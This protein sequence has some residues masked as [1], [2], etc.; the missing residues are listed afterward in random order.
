MMSPL[1]SALL[2]LQYN[3]A[4]PVTETPL[5]A[6]KWVYRETAERGTGFGGHSATL[7]SDDGR[8]RLVVRCDFSYQ[9]DISIQFLRA[10]RSE[11]ITAVPVKLTR[12][13]SDET[14]ALVWEQAASGTFA[15]DGMTD[16]EATQAA[17]TLQD[18]NGELKVEARDTAGRRLK[19]T[20]T[21]LAGHDAIRRTTTACYDL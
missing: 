19:V 7:L 18:Y 16:V 2:I 3:T 6:G 8:Y 10:F 21:A 15:R 11:A 5:E 17:A 14:I 4:Q 20:F 1:L 12:M 13:D 9:S